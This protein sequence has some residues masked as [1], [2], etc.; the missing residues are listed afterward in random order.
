MH[1][2]G[3]IKAVSYDIQFSWINLLHYAEKSSGFSRG[4]SKYRGVARY[5]NLALFTA[6]WF[7]NFPFFLCIGFCNVSISFT[8]DHGQQNKSL[9]SLLNS[10]SGA[11]ANIC[12]KCF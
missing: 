9:I 11:Y 4:V 7:C 10:E 2:Y 5:L 6:K 12:T 1:I 3:A 8:G